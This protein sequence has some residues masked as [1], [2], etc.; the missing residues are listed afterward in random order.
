MSS[1]IPTDDPGVNPRIILFHSDLSAR[2][3]VDAGLLLSQILYWSKY[4]PRPEGF[5]HSLA[6]W[7]DELGCDWTRWRHDQSVKRLT[8]AGLLKCTPRNGRETRYL[9]DLEAV[10]KLLSKLPTAS[11]LYK[12]LLEDS[13]VNDCSGATS[14]PQSCVSNDTT[15]NLAGDPVS[16]QQGTEQTLLVASRVPPNPVSG[17]QG[18]PEEHRRKKN[19]E[20][21]EQED[22]AAAGATGLTGK[23]PEPETN[24]LLK[25][26]QSP[27]SRALLQSILP[28]AST[29]QESPMQTPTP[30]P[31]PAPTPSVQ[32]DSP[33]RDS[34]G[35][36]DGLLDSWELQNV[37]KPSEVIPGSNFRDTPSG[38]QKLD[39]LARIHP[40]NPCNMGK[41]FDVARALRICGELEMR[42]NQ[43]RTGA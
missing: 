33:G 5:W 12:T 39:E 26:I 19:T 42:R 8:A 14:T 21:K 37:R 20:P 1:N 2:L 27:I 3:G 15:P 29:T 43:S 38:R 4:K 13:R 41:D 28:P 16:G 18:L 22:R 24:Q 9:P 7:R 32:P 34:A 31:E 23:E 10:K 35:N 17:Q 40:K 36:S 30:A 11:N 6:Q 25:M